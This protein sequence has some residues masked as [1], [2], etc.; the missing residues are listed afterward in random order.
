M[1]GVEVETDR[2]GF[3]CGN[4]FVSGSVNGQFAFTLGTHI[5]IGF[6]A[7]P[8]NRKDLALGVEVFRTHTECD[9]CPGLRTVFWTARERQLDSAFDF[10]LHGVV[11]KSSNAACDKVHRR[12]ADETCNK[13]IGGIVLKTTA[14]RR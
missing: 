4:G 11:G 9:W 5:E 14:K 12:G 2:N 3:T 13:E 6:S 1:A 7:Q 8:F 10:H